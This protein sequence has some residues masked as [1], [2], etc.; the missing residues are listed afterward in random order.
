MS[1]ANSTS[2]QLKVLRIPSAVANHDRRN[3]DRRS[4]TEPADDLVLLGS[5]ELRSAISSI[6]GCAE[7]IDSGDLADDA[8]LLYTKI[9]L[10]E[11]RR[12]TAF[13]DKA[14]ELQSL[15]RGHRDL[16]LA[17]VD[18]RSLIQRAVR[19]AGEDDLRPIEID[20]PS[21]LPLVAA[22]AEA[23]LEVLTNFISNA[24][25][26]SPNGGSIGISARRLDDMV[27]VE[28]QDEGIG[29]DAEAL[30]KLFRKFY[31]ADTGVGRLTPGSGLG[32]AINHRIVEAHG[33][34]L[35]ASS[36]GLGKGARFKFTV[37]VSPAT[38]TSGKVLIVEDDP[39]FA[40]LLR[41]EFAA[42]G[43]GTVRTAD[44]ETA[45]RLLVDMTPL[46]IV[47]DLVLPGLQGEDFLARLGSVGGARV[48]VVVLTVK[49]LSAGQVSALE[50]AGATA[51]LPKEA[52]APQAAV[53]LIANALA[54]AHS[55]AQ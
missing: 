41:A 7:L 29:I 52:G 26:F 30:P 5:R 45:E 36:R 53:A 32:L 37:P 48:P 21:E 11:G 28:I 12:L 33:G 44:A 15:E 8:I 18:V 27:E 40:S 49:N 10:R 19:A 39:G 22:E 20:V 13:V 31:R 55:D 24:R 46:A 23:I 35:V 54:V 4:E 43:L 38:A 25:R 14:V 2:R 47:L 3:H 51:V 42:E 16:D 6:V 50:L 1:R 17:P 34:R 9:L